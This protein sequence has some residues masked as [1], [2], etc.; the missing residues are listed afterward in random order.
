VSGEVISV[1]GDLEERPELINQDAFGEGW[2]AVIRMDD[3]A[4]LLSLLDAAAYQTFT[5]EEHG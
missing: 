2:I 5:E 1:N 4:E 3:P